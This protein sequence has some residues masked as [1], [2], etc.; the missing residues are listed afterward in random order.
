[1]PSHIP[2][3]FHLP[4]AGGKQPVKLRRRWEGEAPGRKRNSAADPP[5]GKKIGSSACT[6]SAAGL[7]QRA[8][9]CSRY[10]SSVVV[11]IIKNNNERE[12][13]MPVL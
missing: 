1:M 8:S 6:A 11:Q 2:I 13:F 7:A 5:E 9:V 10:S 3:V 4:A 12:V